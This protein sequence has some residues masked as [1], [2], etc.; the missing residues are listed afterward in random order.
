MKNIYTD[1]LADNICFGHMNSGASVPFP[2]Y[3]EKTQGKNL[4]I[5]F[6]KA[7]L[8]SMEGCS[9]RSHGRMLP[10]SHRSILS[11]VTWRGTSDHG[12]EEHG[13]KKHGA[14]KKDNA[15]PVMD[16]P[17][18]RQDRLSP[19]QVAEDTPACLQVLAVERSV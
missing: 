9:P 14:P 4:F 12:V 5:L 15:H 7:S 18:R 8:H 3:S 19:K 2:S 16:P 1:F 13:P 17:G 10:I 6:L 11:Q